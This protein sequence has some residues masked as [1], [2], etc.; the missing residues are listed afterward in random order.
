MGKLVSGIF[1]MDNGTKQAQAGIE[2]GREYAKDVYFKPVTIT[3]LLG[4][5]TGSPEGEY[6]ADLNPRLL[7]LTEQQLGGAEK[8][9][10][11]LTDFDVGSVSNQIYQQQLDMLRPELQAQQ[12]QMQ[13]Q[14]FGTGRLG[15]KLAGV[16]LGA[17]GAGA[18]SP[19]A[20]GLGLA[21]S[22]MLGDLAIKSR[23][24]A[25]GELGNYAGLAS[26]MLGSA[27]G[28]EELSQSLI[29][30]GVQSQAARSA[31]AAAAGQIGTGGYNMATNAAM[32]QDTAMGSF[33]G[34][35][36]GG[37]GTAM[38]KSD[39]SL[40][41]DIKLLGKLPNGINWY[42]WSWNS[43][44]EKLG[45]DKQPTTGVLA[46]EVQ[47]IIPDAVKVDPADGYLM[48]DYSKILEA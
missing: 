43:I 28:I 29:A 36:F 41:E 18:I 21:Q 35:L 33:W 44:A 27:M 9:Y 31:A 24:Q 20:Y 12:N 26:G 14:M 13:E 16:G 17:G 4:Q 1:G 39:I 25:F 5:M 46:Q 8:F 30:Q 10:K 6:S 47:K 48:V 15:L 19:D 2:A 37:V 23:E 42:S 32:N 40:K 38:S 34:G 45:I 22:R 11:T 7:G 3:S